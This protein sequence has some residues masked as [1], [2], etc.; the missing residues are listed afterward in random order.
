MGVGL[1]SPKG[2]IQSKPR[3][4]TRTSV[5]MGVPVSSLKCNI[6]GGWGVD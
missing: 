3:I 4:L 2:R 6:A 5:T 1:G